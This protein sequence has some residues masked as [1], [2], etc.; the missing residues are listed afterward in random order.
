MTSQTT[1]IYELV[2]RHWQ[3][4]L[5]NN[6]CFGCDSIILFSNCETVLVC[7]QLCRRC[8]QAG[9]RPFALRLVVI[10][11]AGVK[12]TDLFNW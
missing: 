12:E 4:L 1:R 2:A 3:P 11:F 9:H 5:L 6:D 8:H 7:V 10:S